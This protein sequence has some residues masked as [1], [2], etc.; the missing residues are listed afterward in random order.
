M[1]ILITNEQTKKILEFFEKNI[2]S[3]KAHTNTWKKRLYCPMLIHKNL[4][5][6]LREKLIYTYP[7]YVIAFD[8]IFE[9]GGSH[10]PYHVD[11]E[12]LGPFIV[13]HPYSFIKDGCFISI[14]FNLTPD[15]GHLKTYNNAFL[16]Y[17]HYHTIVYFGIYSFFHKLLTF[18]SLPFLIFATKYP[19]NIGVGNSFNNMKLHCVTSG[20]PRISYVVRM[21]KKNVTLSK[22]SVKKGISRSDACKSFRELFELVP[23]AEINVGD[24]NWG[25]L[26]TEE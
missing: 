11:Y 24:I 17:I 14:H 9:S 16:S 19:N 12:S 8:V 1:T 15:G 26:S 22:H 18:L 3:E 2:G 10:V 21:V 23:S 20:S 4:L 5:T 6:D 13:K 25:S 7:G